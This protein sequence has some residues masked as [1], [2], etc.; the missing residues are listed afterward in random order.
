MKGHNH[1]GEGGAKGAMLRFL[2]INE[3]NALKTN[4]AIDSFIS[5]LTEQK[6]INKLNYNREVLESQRD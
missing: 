6:K 4:R 5:S 3:E 2:S 1:G